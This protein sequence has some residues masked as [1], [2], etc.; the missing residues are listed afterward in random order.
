VIAILPTL[1]LRRFDRPALGR[2]LLRC[3]LRPGGVR[4]SV[5]ALFVVLFALA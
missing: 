5:M 3:L 2:R 4:P 1:T